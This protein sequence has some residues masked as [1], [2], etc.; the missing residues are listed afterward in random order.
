MKICKFKFTDN[1]KLYYFFLFLF[2]VPPLLKIYGNMIFKIE[3]FLVVFLYLFLIYDFFVNK[4]KLQSFHPVPLFLVIATFFYGVFIGIKN[5][6]DWYILLKDVCFLVF[7]LM[8]FYLLENYKNFINL[9]FLD[10]L[11]GYAVF[12]S[13]LQII[14]VTFGYYLNVDRPTLRHLFLLFSTDILPFVVILKVIVNKKFFDFQNIIIIIAMLSVKSR[15]NLLFVVLFM[16]IYF[17]S[18]YVIDGKKRLFVLMLIIFGFTLIWLFPIFYPPIQNFFGSSLKW[19]YNEWKSLFVF[20]SK[21]SL[22]EILM[23]KGFGAVLPALKPLKVFGKATHY[24]LERFHNIFLFLFFKL[25]VLGVLMYIVSFFLF[26]SQK[27]A[28]L[29]NDA[30]FFLAFFLV[31]L[32]FVYSPANGGFSMSIFSGLILGVV[33]FLNCYNFSLFLG[34]TEK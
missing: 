18:S 20:M 27:V 6:N 33:L 21:Q 11:F 29:K 31:F 34:T 12:V 24:S 16:V 1:K 19:R 23:G 30:N 22:G 5:G 7:P 8:V 17:F 4:K 15:T 28:F 10:N 3:F 25:G 9:D 13:I 26:I 32:L 2:F 14:L